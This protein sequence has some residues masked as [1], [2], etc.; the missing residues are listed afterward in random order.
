MDIPSV[1]TARVAGVS[2]GAYGK[3]YTL[4][5]IDYQV[6][7]VRS[8]DSAFG[9]ISSVDVAFIEAGAVNR[10][11]GAVAS[12]DAAISTSGIVKCGVGIV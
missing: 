12:V 9:L 3:V 6:S 4:D 7:I 1:E 5:S 10:A 8:G 11:V 2:A